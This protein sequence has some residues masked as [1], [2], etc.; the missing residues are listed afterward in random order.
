MLDFG[1]FRK[2]VTKDR[3]SA[4][5]QQDAFLEYRDGVIGVQ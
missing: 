4:E 3:L 1:E 5:N 2:L